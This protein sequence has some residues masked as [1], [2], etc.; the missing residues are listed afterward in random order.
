MSFKSTYLNYFQILLVLIV[1][2]ILTNVINCLYMK[3]ELYVLCSF[4]DFDD[5]LLPVHIH[6]Y[7]LQSLS[8]VDILHCM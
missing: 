6:M 1:M 2:N 7:C 8:A 4:A 3:V 5:H